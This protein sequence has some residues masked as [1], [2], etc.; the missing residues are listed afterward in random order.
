MDLKTILMIS[1]IV[2]A[3]GILVYL[4]IKLWRKDGN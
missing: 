3:F 4:S 2:L 1:G